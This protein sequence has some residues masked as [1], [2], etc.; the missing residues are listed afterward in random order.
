[1]PWQTYIQIYAAVTVAYLVVTALYL[2]RR[3]SQ[4]KALPP[5]LPTE[6]LHS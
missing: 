6:S 3:F 4:K 5:A 1:M 2:L